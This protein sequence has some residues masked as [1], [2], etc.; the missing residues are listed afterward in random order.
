[1]ARGSFDASGAQ[2]DLGELARCHLLCL[3]HTASSRAG[4]PVLERLYGTLLADPAARVLWRPQ[5]EPPSHWGGFA[6]GSTQ[7]RET[8][9]RVRGG[10]G[11][12]AAARLAMQLARMPGHVL[13]RRRWEALIPRQGIGYVL[14]LGS[15]RAVERTAASVSGTELLG[16]LEAWFVTQDCGEAWVDTELQ[17]RRAHGFYLRHGYVEVA[18]DFGQVLLKKPLDASSM[19]L[20]ARS[21]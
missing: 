18:R 16:A 1:M 20:P 4:L 13:A 14:T 15:A 17:N 11:T 6:A 9:A 19:A 10:L 8:E 3:P 2:F 12:I 5:P 7:I 21:R